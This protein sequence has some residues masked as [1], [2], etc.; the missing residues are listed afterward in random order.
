[1]ASQII[2]FGNDI[3]SYNKQE[4]LMNNK[5]EPMSNKEMEQQNQQNYPYGK[6][7]SDD[8]IQRNFLAMHSPTI[9]NNQPPQ[10]NKIFPEQNMNYQMNNNNQNII[11]GKIVNRAQ[12][13]PNMGMNRQLTN[14]QPINQQQPLKQIQLPMKQ[15]VPNPGM[16][17]LGNKPNI[18]MNLKPME[19]LYAN[20]PGQLNIIQRPP[21]LSPSPR[22]ISQNVY[23]K[24][25]V[26]KN[27]PIG[28]KKNYDCGESSTWN[29]N[30]RPFKH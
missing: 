24:E 22:I 20:R 13:P 11:R 5:E 17:Q 28:Q 3:F 21:N 15:P 30:K 18:N 19:P 10:F 7:K 2:T 8:N 27:N 23:A 25:T 6:M 12:Y 26:P 16:N 9:K 4:P 29:T 14:N 1:M